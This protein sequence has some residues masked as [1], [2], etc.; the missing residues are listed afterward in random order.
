MCSFSTLLPASGDQRL[1]TVVL[2]DRD[3]GRPM[4]GADDLPPADSETCVAGVVQDLQ[5]TT[6]VPWPRLPVL[7]AGFGKPASIVERARDSATGL[8]RQAEPEKQLECG[9]ALRVDL[10]SL[11]DRAVL[12]RNGQPVPIRLRARAFTTIDGA[13]A[14][15]AARE[16]LAARVLM[17]ALAGHHRVRQVPKRVGVLDRADSHLPLE[18]P[19]R[20]LDCVTCRAPIATC[21]AVT[22]LRP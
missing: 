17:V 2:T 15:R 22:V 3:I 6:G 20:D 19:Q 9:L 11:D 13:S 4:S 18:C 1:Q 12:D 7:D 16:T 21:K 8:T 10:K 14:S 5:H